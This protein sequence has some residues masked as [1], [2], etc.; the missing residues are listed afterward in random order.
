VL[1]DY[2]KGE[3]T[4]DWYQRNA[5]SPGNLDPGIVP[6]YLLLIGP[7]DLIPFEF[8]YL[9]GVEYA[10]GRLA[11]DT[12]EE[13]AR[14]A[15]SIVTYES[16][17]SVPNSREVHYWG[18]RHAGDGATNLSASLLIDPLANG[19]PTSA[20][21]LK[22]AINSLYGFDRKLNLGED[23]TKA[24][25]LQS[26]RAAKPPAMLFTASHGLAMH[27][28]QDR[29]ADIQGALLC[30]DWPGF[31][32]MRPEH[33]LA[34]TDIADDANVSGV[35]ALLFACFGAGTPDTNQFLKDLSQAGDAPPLA[36]KP[37]IAALPRRL[38]AHPN[39]SA[40]AVIGHV[41]QAWGFSMQ[42]AKV[43]GPQIAAFRNSIGT[44][45]SG[46]PVGHAMSKYFGA[47]FAE[48]SA[49]LLSATS[50]TAP[51]AMKLSDRDLAIRWI[52]RNDAQN[53][54]LLGDPAVRIRKDALA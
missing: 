23:A 43:A 28:G 53:Y 40:L 5:T 24:N 34:A 29:Q 6:Y 35:V 42:D 12:A 45:L 50:P 33:C 20:G 48:L 54:L 22:Q 7:P 11:F 8:Q 25:L 47:K 30:Q 49:L 10:V 16:G 41:D 4:R 52:E 21:A 13:Y 39:G 36:P 27:S 51:A 44:I 1:P 37:F 31:G 15:R 17:K 46:A 9:L 19:V 14:Y 32:S 3:Q 26:L 2:R 38:L 18:T